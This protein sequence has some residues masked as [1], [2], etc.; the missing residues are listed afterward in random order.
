MLKDTVWGRILSWSETK[1]LCPGFE[2]ESL[3]MTI[4]FDKYVLIN[5]PDMPDTAGEA[6][7]SSYGV[8]SCGPPHISN[9]KQDDQL[10]HTYSSYVMIRDVTLKTCQRRWMIGRRGERGSGISVLA[11][12][13][14]DEWTIDNI[15][16]YIYIERER[17]REKERERKTKWE[18]SVY[19][20][21][22]VIWTWN[23][24]IPYIS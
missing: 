23:L 16:I 2:L 12:R 3:I 19:K 17:E 5:E 11:A 20:L 13:H 21:I 15:Y 18:R 9:Q 24:S 1:S 4:I 6:R 10:E 7:T 8:Y 22:F 14:D